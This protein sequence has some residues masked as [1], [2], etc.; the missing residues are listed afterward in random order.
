LSY[1]LV[2][3]KKIYKFQLKNIQLKQDP[4]QWIKS[5]RDNLS[6]LW[7]KSWDWDSPIE[8]K[9]NKNTVQFSTNSI[10]NDGI[11]KKWKKKWKKETQ[12]NSG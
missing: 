5:T 12:V 7:L 8:R 2:K 4:K 11:K 1:W 9:L 3:L 10:F 6:N